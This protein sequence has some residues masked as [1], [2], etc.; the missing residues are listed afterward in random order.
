MF[1]NRKE[2]N[3]NGKIPPMRMD[4]IFKLPNFLRKII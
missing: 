2:F 1:F 3:H 4:V